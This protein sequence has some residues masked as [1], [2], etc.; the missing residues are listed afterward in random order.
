MRIPR[1]ALAALLAG[2]ALCATAQ[3][4]VYLESADKELD[5][6]KAPTTSK[7][8]FDG[9]RM[10]TER[11]E[12]SGEQEVVIFKNQ[13]LY[14]VDSKSKSYRVIDKATADQMGA[15]VAAAKK[16]MEA[17]MAAMPPDQRK[18]MEEM[19]AKIGKGAA[20]AMMPGAKPSQRTLTNTGRT[21]TVAGIQCTVW[22]AIDGGRKEQELC[23]APASSIPGGDDVIKTFRE[24][25]TMMSAFTEKLGG[26]GG[27]EPWHDME[28]LN[29]VPILTREFDNGKATS[30][31]RM[32]V[33]RKESVPAASFEV[34]AGYAEKK[35][36][37]PGAKAH[38]GDDD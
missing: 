38:G 1:L 18:K 10:R 9:G 17:R 37:I 24:I 23:A 16:Q 7:M 5:G 13:T 25:S 30:E 19:M 26:R 28:T 27:D 22:E 6:S 12:R 3:A 14:T 32:T 2:S 29:G 35:L 31:M 34:P 33:V 11:A 20:G 8:W 15:Q 21:E 36:N 4:G